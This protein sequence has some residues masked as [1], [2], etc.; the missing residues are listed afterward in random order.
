MK[1][2]G[3]GSAILPD[4]NKQ[5]QVDHW[6]IYRPLRELAKHVDWEIEHSPTFIPSFDQ[7][8]SKDEFTEA[9]FQKAYENLKEYDIIFSSYH[10]DPSAFTLMQVLHDREG[11]Q[12]VMDVD[13]DMFAINPDN[14]FW[15]KM[16]H[17]KVYQMQRMIAHNAWI[18]TPSQYLAQRFRDRRK[19]HPDDSVTVIP[20]FISD[21]YKHPDFDNSPDVVIGYMGGSSHYYDLHDSGVL[22]AIQ[23]IMHEDKN[24]RLKLLGMFS[25]VYTPKQR[26]S[27]D[28]GVRGTKF[29]TDLFPTMQFDIALAPLLDNEFNKGKSNIK[30][31]ESTRAGGAFVCSNVGPYRDLP[32]TNAV[33]VAENTVDAWYA[34]LKPLVT[35]AAKRKELVDNSRQ[36]VMLNWKLENNW[37][38][39]K[40]L[41]ERVHKEGT[42]ADRRTIMGLSAGQ[43]K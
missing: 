5:S 23:K 14:P 16:T 35:D 43:A 21:D 36:D 31:Q 42:N 25:D 32:H 27:F 39:Y 7:L 3:V 20:N 40:D 8:K 17:E 22:E 34:A 6:R 26:T 4:H 19:G 33:K 24:V 11:V 37:Q 18:T 12:F 38:H 41:F 10:P 29:L 9:E 13:D 30:W 28:P 2:L 15:L 1:I